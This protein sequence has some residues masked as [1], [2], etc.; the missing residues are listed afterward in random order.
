MLRD[1]EKVGED[2]SDHYLDD[3]SKASRREREKNRA[4]SRLERREEDKREEK[5]TTPA[6]LRITLLA[7][8]GAQVE[9]VFSHTVMSHTYYI[10]YVPCRESKKI[11]WD[12]RQTS[13]DLIWGLSVPVLPTEARNS[14]GC[15]TRSSPAV[16]CTEAFE[17]MYGY[18]K[19]QRVAADLNQ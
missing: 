12:W 8:S 11:I 10:K 7:S 2:S 13:V 17:A 3:T 16:L 5:K 15:L 19:P 1:R 9:Y 18:D 14:C 6:P 4:G